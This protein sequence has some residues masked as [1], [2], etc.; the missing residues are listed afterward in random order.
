MRWTFA[1]AG[2]AVLSVC[3]V[4]GFAAARR[5]RAPAAPLHV[6]GMTALLVPGADATKYAVTATDSDPAAGL[7][8]TWTLTLQPVDPA[9]LIG[10]PVI[11]PPTQRSIPGATTKRSPA[12]CT[13]S[14]AWA[15]RPL[16]PGL[17][18]EEPRAELHL[19]TGRPARM[20]TIRATS[21]NRALAGPSGNQGVV[22]VVVSD[23][24]W[25]CSASINGSSP[26]TAPDTGPVCTRI[27]PAASP[28][29][30]GGAGVEVVAH[31]IPRPTSLVSGAGDGVARLEP[32][33]P[34]GGVFVLR[35][36]RAVRIPRLPLLSGWPG[37]EERSTGRPAR[38][39]TRGAAGPGRGSHGRGSSGPGRRASRG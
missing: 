6:S 36:G 4:C 35:G 3:L 12:V 5:Y 7:G 9:R 33:A 31:G 14:Q 27:A 11:L 15:S 32:R 26:R 22:G 25:D 10:L 20:P 2:A 17:H 30:V 8:S 24:T 29:A 37:T 19:H 21:C 39:S 38:S 16:R 13:P 23:G 18:L 1:Q 28:R 34:G